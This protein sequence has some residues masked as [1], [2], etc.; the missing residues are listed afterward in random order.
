MPQEVFTRLQSVSAGPKTPAGIGQEAQL[1]IALLQPLI[2]NSPRPSQERPQPG[3]SLPSQ[4]R[5]SPAAS[6]HR[7]PSPATGRS[8]DELSDLLSSSCLIPGIQSNAIGDEELMSSIEGG[9]SDILM[10]NTAQPYSHDDLDADETSLQKRDRRVDRHGSDAGSLSSRELGQLFAQYAGATWQPAVSVEPDWFSALDAGLSMPIHDW[11]GSSL[12]HANSLLPEAFQ[13]RERRASTFVTEIPEERFARIA[14][15]WPKKGGR[16]WQLIQTLW[17]DVVA[18][19]GGNL[20]SNANDINASL[21]ALHP[22][23]AEAR[24]QLDDERRLSMIKEY[25]IVG[26]MERLPE[27]RF[28]TADMLEICIDIYFHRFHPLM[29]FIHEPTFSPRHT[30]NMIVFPVCLIGLLL[31][32]PKRTRGFVAKHLSK[33]IEKCSDALSSPWSKSDSMLLLTR[34]ASAV[35]LLSCAAMLEVCMGHALR[36]LMRSTYKWWQEHVHS[37]QAFA[38][39]SKTLTLAQQNSLFE[40]NE[41][42]SLSSA[43]PQG[44]VDDAAWKAWAKTE[45]SKRMIVCLVM[46][47]SFFSYHM[48]TAPIIRVD[49]MQLYMPCSTLLFATADAN[50]WAELD[51]TRLS[52]KPLIMDFRPYQTILPADLPSSLIGMMALLSGVS[53]R[54]ADARYRLLLQPHTSNHTVLVPGELYHTDPSGASI[55]PLLREIHATYRS[56]LWRN[57]PNHMV[58]WHHMCIEITANLDLFEVAAG[59]DG[60]SAGKSALDSISIWAESPCARRAC[61]HAAQVYACMSRRNVADGTTFLAENSLFN[62]ALV[63]GLYAIV[64][65]ESLQEG[66]RSDEDIPFELLDEVDWD[67]IGDGGF[68]SYGSSYTSTQT[69]ARRFI[70]SGGRISFAG[71][72]YSRGYRLARRIILEYIGLLEE[73]GK[74]NVAELCRILRILSEDTRID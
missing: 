56:D 53:L 74:W 16:P 46:I 32:D 15:Q 54:L 48:R 3:P 27:L 40:A 35:L 69:A 47:D 70:I 5:D 50:R 7:G 62:S 45:S 8:R 71:I 19:G 25:G 11:G 41:G 60:S 21:D 10:S 12:L 66:P 30:P 13:R 72:A 22:S 17:T 31:L 23:K 42:L 67:D 2:Q 20:F 64:M 55:V 59:R 65:P 14:R 33:A 63:L 6:N 36:C 29:P 57:N 68:P 38:L 24:N 4:Q 39:Y 18:H 73:V 9:E 26:G 1:G 44:R 61:L 58:F 28:P 34:L 49:T 51:A 37:E 52:M 43:L